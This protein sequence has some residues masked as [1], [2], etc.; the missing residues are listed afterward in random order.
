MSS[1]TREEKCLLASAG[2]SKP[3]DYNFWNFISQ[4]FVKVGTHTRCVCL[5]GNH[6]AHRKYFK[7]QPFVG[8]LETPTTGD[9][10]K[11]KKLKTVNYAISNLK[12][13]WPQLGWSPLRNILKEL[14]INFFNDYHIYPIEF[15]ISGNLT[16]FKLMRFYHGWA[17]LHFWAKADVISTI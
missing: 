15:C 2:L 6:V 11:T 13:I 7:N 8:V 12:V 10:G 1:L 3:S 17:I 16:Q 14:F 5:E 4:Y 9:K